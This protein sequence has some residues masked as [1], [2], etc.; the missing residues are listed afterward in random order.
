MA[1]ETILDLFHQPAYYRQFHGSDYVPKE[2]QTRLTGQIMRLYDL[3]K[4]GNWLT[5]SE[6]ENE[7]NKRH[8]NH[9]HPQASLSAQ[10]RNL[11]RVEFGSHVIIK[12][13]RGD[14]SRGLFE[15]RLKH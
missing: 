7:L 1:H 11:R 14:R 5:L 6:M 9:R 2:D 3:L 4:E 10:I 8:P 15:Y 13:T 12:Q